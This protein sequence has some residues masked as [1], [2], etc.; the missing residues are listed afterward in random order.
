M[1]KFGKGLSIEQTKSYIKML[2]NSVKKLQHERDIYKQ[3]CKELIGIESIYCC[4]CNA[5]LLDETNEI[6]VLAARCNSTPFYDFYQFCKK[7]DLE[8]FVKK[9]DFGNDLF[10]DECINHLPHKTI[11]VSTFSISFMPSG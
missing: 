6:E 4:E 2:E 7:E 1:K 3:F 8:S 11:N 9:H 5:K 10:V